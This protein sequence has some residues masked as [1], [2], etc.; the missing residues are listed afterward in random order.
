METIKD[1]LT[2]IG[3]ILASIFILIFVCLLIA[4]VMLATFSPI[5]AIVYL[6]MDKI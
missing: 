4:L 3:V 6:I 1:I 5:I 2:I